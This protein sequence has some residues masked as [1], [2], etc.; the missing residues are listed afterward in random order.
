MMAVKNKCKLRDLSKTK[1]TTS[2]KKKWMMSNCRICTA[3]QQITGWTSTTLCGTRSSSRGNPQSSLA[4]RTL[5]SNTW[6]PSSPFISM[7]WKASL[8]QGGLIGSTPTI[9]RREEVS[10]AVKSRWQA[11]VGGKSLSNRCK[12]WIPTGTLYLKTESIL[13]FYILMIL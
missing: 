2:R 5:S 8:S 7:T 3:S 6:S 12:R 10:R 11:G 9:A 1:I 13:M 4:L